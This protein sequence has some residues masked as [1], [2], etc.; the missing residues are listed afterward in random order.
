MEKIFDIRQFRHALAFFSIIRV[1]T[2]GEADAK[3]MVR[4]FSYAGLIIGSGLAIVS[5]ASS[6][7]FS[8]WIG[9]FLM[10]LYLS[11]I[12]GGLHLDGLA[13]TADGL[14]SHRDKDRK[15]EIMRDSRL[16]T[17]GAVALVLILLGKFVAIVEIKSLL[18][19]IIIPAYARLSMVLCLYFLKYPRDKGLAADFFSEYD[20]DVF[21]Q[22]IPLLILSLFFG[23]FNAILFN[24]IFFVVC[25][26][27]IQFYKKSIGGVTGD[28]LGA[29]SEFVETVL[30][31]SVCT[32]V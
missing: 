3:S 26:L 20:A 22:Y 17:M 18:A 16:G 19:F 15:L 29:S 6:L 10:V 5:W 9:G 23:I 8:D 7:F 13:D 30:F 32:L 2:E 28:M 25:G 4:H 27:V 24:I 12:T 21:Y 31:I 11:V 14:F 1:N